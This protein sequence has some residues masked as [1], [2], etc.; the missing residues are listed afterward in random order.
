MEGQFDR[1]SSGRQ[2]GDVS[3]TCWPGKRVEVIQ[4]V[5]ERIGDLRPH[6]G[7]RER[8]RYHDSGRSSF[9][10]QPGGAFYVSSGRW[11]VADKKPGYGSEQR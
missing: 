11:L 4:R 3:R 1:F 10:H 7:E 5:H 9:S 6:G 8:I 2:R